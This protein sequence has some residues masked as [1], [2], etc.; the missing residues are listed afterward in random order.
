MAFAQAIG[1]E[2]GD[3][4][5]LTLKGRDGG[6][7]ATSRQPPLDHDKATWLM[8]VGKKRPAAGWPKGRYV[9]EF[10]VYRAGQAVISRSFA[11]DL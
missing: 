3:Q 6:T 11:V 2:A 9:A 4:P 1:L 10:K 5:E 7:I 8:F